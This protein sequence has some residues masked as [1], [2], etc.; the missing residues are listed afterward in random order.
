MITTA[1]GEVVTSV[2]GSAAIVVAAVDVCVVAV[3]V[4]V[5]GPVVVE[6]LP[7]RS[8]HQRLLDADQPDKDSETSHW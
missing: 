4:M 8:Q 1:A 5:G 7:F 3:V 2:V 6:H